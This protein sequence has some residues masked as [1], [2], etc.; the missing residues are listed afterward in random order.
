MKARS[1]ALVAFLVASVATAHAGGIN[2]GG[3]TNEGGTGIAGAAAASNATAVAVQGQVQGQAQHQNAQAISGGNSLA[4]NVAAQVRDPVSS[5]VA[6]SMNP[7]TQCA[8]PIVGGFAVANLS[9]SGGSAYEGAHCQKIEESKLASGLGDRETA[10]EI[11]CELSYY[12]AA[13][14]R[15]GRPCAADKP[16]PAKAAAV[17]QVSIQGYTGSDPYVIQRLSK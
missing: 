7:T 9:M 11:A 16:A 13:R 4:V 1:F 15:V 12:R 17:T 10:Q 6:P 3:T 5:A 2:L 14:A 8:L